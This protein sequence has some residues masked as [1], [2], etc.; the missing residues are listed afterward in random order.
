[1]TKE[2][3]SSA[4]DIAETLYTVDQ[5]GA[6]KLAKRVARETGKQTGESLCCLLFDSFS[7]SS[8]SAHKYL[9]MKEEQKLLENGNSETTK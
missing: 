1:M 4:L 7:E 5:L 3:L 8:F 2:G 6:K 9:E